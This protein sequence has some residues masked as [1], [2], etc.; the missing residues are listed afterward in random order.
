MTETVAASPKLGPAVGEDLVVMSFCDE[1]FKAVD[2]AADPRSCGQAKDGSWSAGASA[3]LVL[4]VWDDF[5]TEAGP[6]SV[7]QLTG[8]NGGHWEIDEASGSRS[9]L[10]ESGG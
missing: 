7:I 1:S 4:S 10:V 5:P 9:T 2:P 8:S 6:T 3:L